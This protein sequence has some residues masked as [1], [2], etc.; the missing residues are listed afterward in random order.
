M[1]VEASVRVG[2]GT[3]AS[4]AECAHAAAEVSVAVDVPVGVDVQDA[5]ERAADC[6]CIMS[7]RRG[8]T[9]RRGKVKI[10]QNRQRLGENNPHCGMAYDNEKP[11]QKP[12]LGRLVDRR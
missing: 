8:E 10:K 3:G 7:N 6:V 4:I 5:T 9:S 12:V 1:R 11:S 2:C